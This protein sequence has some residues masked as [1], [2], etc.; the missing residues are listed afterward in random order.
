MDFEDN[1]KSIKYYVKRYVMKNKEQFKDK[2][3]VDIPAG[4]GVTSNIIREAGGIPKPFDIFPDYFQIED[5]LCEKADI[6]AGLPLEDKS[7]DSIVCQEGIEHF[8]DQYKVLRE[9]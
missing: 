9:C 2:I 5:I 7:V 1:P 3:V 4:N 6:M 8:S